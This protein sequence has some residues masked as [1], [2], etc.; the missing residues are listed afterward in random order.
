MKVLKAFQLVTC[1]S[2]LGMAS[3]GTFIIEDMSY[4]LKYN[5]YKSM[6]QG[7]S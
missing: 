1:S 5:E 6:L 4:V 2:T 7:I 3:Y